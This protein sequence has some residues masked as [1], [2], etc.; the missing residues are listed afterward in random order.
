MN[1]KDFLIQLWKRLFRPLIVLAVIYFSVEFLVAVFSENGTGRF[2]TVVILSL[3]LLFTLA[4]LAGDLLRTIRQ[5]IYAGL[6]D[7]TRSRLQLMGKITDYLAVLILGAVLY[8]FWT[9]DAVLATIL[10]LLLLIDRVTHMVREEKLRQ[11][12][13]K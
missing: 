5:R 12:H 2:V 10:I 6:S 4:Y 9:I 11:P 3:T 8:K 13:E 7:K 1:R